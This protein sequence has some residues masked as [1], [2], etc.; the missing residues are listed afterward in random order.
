MISIDWTRYQTDIAGGWFETQLKSAAVQDARFRFVFIHNS[1]YY[2]RWHVDG[3]GQ[4][5]CLGYLGIRDKYVQLIEKYNVDAS[6]SGHMHGY[7]RGQRLNSTKQNTYYCV[8][9]GGSY[10]EPSTPY[11]GDID[12]VFI[13]RGSKENTPAHFNYGLVN[14][15][16]TI[17]VHDSLAIARM[18]GF[19]SAGTY[20]GVLDSFVMIDKKWDPTSGAA[21]ISQKI[22]SF[23]KL[24]GNILKVVPP[25]PSKWTLTF[26]L[27]NGSE[28]MS[29]Q[30]NSNF[31]FD[32]S[33]IPSGVYCV[34]LSGAM[35]H[36]SQRITLT[37]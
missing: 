3:E 4:V 16:V 31:S 8:T 23:V 35:G 17:D 22:V 32:C 33:S 19:S 26:H 9:G 6:I 36:F 7:E 37:R 21:K 20:Y 5:E 18:H 13:T 14:E 30:I 2:E 10:L 12:Y 34:T 25:V 1:P 27:L 24:T 15:V 28:I 29:V 11:T